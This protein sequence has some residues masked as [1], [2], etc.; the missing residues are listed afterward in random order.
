MEERS[1]SD[2]DKNPS[3]ELSAIYIID[4]LDHLQEQWQVR[5]KISK[6]VA[7]KS[8]TQQHNIFG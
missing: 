4:W 5:I 8:T 7:A 1:V 2:K 6:P 3:Q